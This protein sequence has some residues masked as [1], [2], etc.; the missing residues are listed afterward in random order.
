VDDEE[1]AR[2]LLKR[3]LA[4]LDASIIEAENGQKALEVLA[5]RP[6]HLVISNVM[7]PVMGGLEFLTRFKQD[8]ATASTPVIMLT[9][10]GSRETRENALG[11]GADDY[12]TKPVDLDDLLPRIR[13]FIG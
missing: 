2:L 4:E 9:S 13:H 8:R 11:L 10:D 5:A 1:P 6:V 12:S 7:M 3:L